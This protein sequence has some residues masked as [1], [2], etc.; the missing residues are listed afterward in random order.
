[1]AHAG[2]HPHHGNI[3][4]P[5]C[6]ALLTLDDE[7]S[8]V[9]RD[10]PVAPV[11]VYPGRLSS[12]RIARSDVHAVHAPSLPPNGACTDEPELLLL[13]LVTLEVAAPQVFVDQTARRSNPVLSRERGRGR[14]IVPAKGPRE[15]DGA[16]IAAGVAIVGAMLGLLI[17]LASGYG[18]T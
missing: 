9:L 11:T 17:V 5:T 18:A 3:P 13:D 4:V 1:M 2:T 10:P 15:G 16:L 12:R 7:V 14:Q 8:Q 6:N